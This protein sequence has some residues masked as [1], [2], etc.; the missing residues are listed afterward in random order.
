[1]FWLVNSALFLA[2]F[3]GDDFLAKESNTMNYG[4]VFWP[5]AMV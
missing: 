5:E 1:M 3:R 2:W 4:L